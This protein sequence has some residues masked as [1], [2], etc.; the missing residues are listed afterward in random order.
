MQERDANWQELLEPPYRKHA[1]SMV[2]CADG[3]THLLLEGKIWAKPSGKGCGIG[4]APITR[5]PRT[6]TG[7]W[8]P[9]QRIKDMDTEGIDTA[10]NFG[11]TVFKLP[12]L[13]IM[14]WLA[15]SP[16]A[17]TLAR[18]YSKPIRDA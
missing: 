17:T 18:Q 5:K 11:T 7:M 6:T 4:T 8:D 14:T 15:P 10:V 2:Q 13:E 9:V 3:R 1:P 12:F 16:M